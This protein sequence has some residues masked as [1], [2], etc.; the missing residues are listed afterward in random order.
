[1]LI[2][3]AIH[4]EI[5]ATKTG[6]KS[7]PDRGAKYIKKF[8]DSEAFSPRNGICVEFCVELFKV[9]PT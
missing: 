8:H 3:L 6:P 4:F 5:E 9:Q 7:S 2:G 1:M